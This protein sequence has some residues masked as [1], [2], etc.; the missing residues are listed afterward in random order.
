MAQHVLHS[1]DGYY[2]VNSEDQISGNVYEAWGPFSQCP[3]ADEFDVF[4]DPDTMADDG[5]Y[6]TH[7]QDGDLP[8][9]INTRVWET[10]NP[11]TLTWERATARARVYDR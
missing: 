2:I 3:E 8:D 10:W 6:H 5:A 1:E 4:T 9:V 7:E 11:R